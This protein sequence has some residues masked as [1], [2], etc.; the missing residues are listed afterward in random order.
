MIGLILSFGIGLGLLIFLLLVWRRSQSVSP[1]GS[2]Q[3]LIDARHALQ[4]L[5]TGLLPAEFVGRL[6][7][8]EDWDYVKSSAPTDVQKQ[9]LRERKRISISWVRRVRTERCV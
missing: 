7:N 4:R 2:G 8:H 9:F 6:F 1:E 5:Q 3:K